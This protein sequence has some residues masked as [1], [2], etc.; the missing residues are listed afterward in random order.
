MRY[1][2]I[3]IL[4][5][6]SSSL[7]SY[8]NRDSLRFQLKIGN[9]ILI[10]KQKTYRE[11]LVCK[12][13]HCFQGEFDVTNKTTFFNPFI[14]ISRNYRLGNSAKFELG[15]I[16]GFQYLKLE[17]IKIGEWTNY[18]QLPS[19]GYFKGTI[20]NIS[21][22]YSGYFA[23]QPSY[24]LF[25]EGKFV[26][27]CKINLRLDSRIQIN[28]IEKSNG[29]NNYNIPVNTSSKSEVRYTGLYLISFGTLEGSYK[30][31]K[32][33]SVSAE[34]GVPLFLLNDLFDD[35]ETDP[36]KIYY[37]TP[38]YIK[39]YRSSLNY[40]NYITFNTSLILQF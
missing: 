10:P 28:Y 37:N 20:Q 35:E 24:R 3:Y 27:K 17:N 1:S 22:E 11:K 16:L 2:I 23:L 30:L 6:V 33:V 15:L 4:L 25:S 31:T 39:N 14:E 18:S 40:I 36:F 8:S 9:R 21:K 7:F 19:S 13:L 12:S 29:I 26:F 5:L 38:S 34:L 32:K